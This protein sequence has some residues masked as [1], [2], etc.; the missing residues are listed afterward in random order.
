MTIKTYVLI[1]IF[2][3]FT[4]RNFFKNWYDAVVDNDWSI[5]N[6]FIFYPL[7]TIV[8]FLKSACIPA[9]LCGFC[10]LIFF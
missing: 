10:Y 2:I 5:E 4:L 6:D 9:I 7:F 8:H 1:A 3:V